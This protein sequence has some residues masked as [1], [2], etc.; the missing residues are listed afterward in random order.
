MGVAAE[1]PATTTAAVTKY[2]KQEASTVSAAEL[3]RAQ[4]DDMTEAMVQN[5][6]AQREARGEITTSDDI[7]RIRESIVTSQKQ[8]SASAELAKAGVPGL[9]PHDKWLLGGGVA[10]AGAGWAG[11]ELTKKE[12]DPWAAVSTP[13]PQVPIFPGYTGRSS[14]H[15]PSAAYGGIGNITVP[16]VLPIVQTVAADEDGLYL[17]WKAVDVLSTVSYAEGAAIDYLKTGE[18]KGIGAKITPSEALGITPEG[19]DVALWRHAL[20]LV[21][22]IGIDPTTYLSFGS[23]SAVKVVGT[24][25]SKLALSAKGVKELGTMRKALTPRTAGI[26]KDAKRLA[27]GEE[28]GTKEFVA[29]IESDPAFR[30]KVLASEGMSLRGW[31]PLFPGMEKEILSK[32]SM[33][34]ML[35]GPRAVLSAAEET[36]VGQGLARKFVAFHDIKKLARPV[37]MPAGE[38]EYVDKYFAYKKKVPYIQKQAIEEATEMAKAAKE[39]LGDDYQ[40]IMAQLIEMPVTRGAS[41]VPAEARRI[42]EVI[43]A[44]HKIIAE[45]EKARGILGTEIESMGY[46]K[47]MLTP[48]SREYLQAGK[49]IPGD[50]TG[51]WGTQTG[52]SIQRGHKGMLT[53]INEEARKTLGFDLFEPDPFTAFA[54][55]KVESIKAVETY[56]YLEYVEKYYGKASVLPGEAAQFDTVGIQQL[57]GVNLPK[58]IA[59]HLSEEFVA[60]KSAFR[61]T[62]DK[63]LTAWKY[64]ATVPFPAYH[65]QNVVGGLGYNAMLLGDTSVLS[66][67]ALA[68]ILKGKGK[69]KRYVNAL[70]Q[71]LTG[72]EILQKL[73]E[74]GVLGQ[75]GQVDIALEMRTKL[76][77]AKTLKEGAKDVVEAPKTGYGRRGRDPRVDGS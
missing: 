29:R 54:T 37:H 3:A 57:K 10:L 64:G 8:A 59:E 58:P 23:G 71:E 13:L 65:T 12:T 25:G 45:A 70:G 6:A 28:M 49:K 41:D 17:L 31:R 69:S 30:K 42:A 73:G 39:A 14:R 44:E 43:E 63:L 20:G 19:E 5:V 24:G 34:W 1:E 72:E 18:W 11:Y 77:G 9:S 15:D 74:H 21:V 61:E 47:H 51:R 52:S 22:D 35:T 38:A 62:Y 66:V 40:E 68:D 7:Q 33:D 76:G 50:I 75:P 32:G 36:S 67:A 2:P 46:L 27:I 16:A 26:M 48:E 56:D 4:A 53:E 60:Q 55:R